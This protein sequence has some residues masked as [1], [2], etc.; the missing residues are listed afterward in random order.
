MELKLNAAEQ[1]IL[2][3]KSIQEKIQQ[4]Y[5]QLMADKEEQVR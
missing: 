4:Q 2:A 1:Q 5:R 3:E